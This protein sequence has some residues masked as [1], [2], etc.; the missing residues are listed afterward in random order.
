MLFPTSL[1]QWTSPPLRWAALAAIASLVLITT[2]LWQWPRDDH[3]TYGFAGVSKASGASQAPL[4]SADVYNTTLGFEKVFAIGLPSRTDKHDAAALGASMI[5][6]DL[7]WIDGVKSSDLTPQAFPIGWNKDPNAHQPGM[8]GSWRAH[9]N[10]LQ[11]VVS[12]RLSTA[13]I[14]EDDADYD[15]SLKVQLDQFSH[16]ARAIQH[17]ESTTPHSPYGDHWDLLW[18]GHH[19]AI[20]RENETN[21]YIIPEDITAVPVR[22]NKPWHVPAEKFFQTETSRLVFPQVRG[23]A[24][25]AY[26]VT[27]AGAQRILA[28]QSMEHMDQNFDE[29][30]GRMCDPEEETMVLRCIAPFPT[31]IGAFKRQGP[32]SWTS[33]NWFDS[34]AQGK[35]DQEWE[36]A[37]SVGVMYSVM[38]NMKRLLL[39]EKAKAQF[40]DWP[41]QESDMNAV[42]ALHGHLMDESELKH[43]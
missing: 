40:D 2:L 31:I 27:L 30:L 34:K 4:Y 7:N 8:V 33:D 36:P 13:L 26:G 35:N 38:L 15:V 17:Q 43:T 23:V 28:R 9:M 11:T 39:G 29:K 5:E 16:G 18:L 21:I 12:L 14:I 37:R 10:A 41:V 42:R 24:T 20:P 25:Y 19:G 22:H 1:S 3:N 6:L 32:K